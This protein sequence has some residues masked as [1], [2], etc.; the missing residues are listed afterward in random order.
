MAL[1]ST[2]LYK[3]ETASYFDAQM[4]FSSNKLLRESEGFR[5]R[6]ASLRK[7]RA[8]LSPTF[9]QK[10]EPSGYQSSENDAPESTTTDD[11]NVHVS[12]KQKLVRLINEARTSQQLKTEPSSTSSHVEHSRKFMKETKDLWSSSSERGEVDST[13]N[14]NGN[15]DV[16]KAIHDAKKWRAIPD[17][18][19]NEANPIPPCLIY[20]APHLLRLFVEMPQMLADSEVTDARVKI[21]LKHVSLFLEKYVV[22]ENQLFNVNIYK[23]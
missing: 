12:K 15:K 2:L 23:K 7:R 22:N 9:W 3:N 1:S 20:G 10:R 16:Q 11:S 18:S 13:S 17:E 19:L 21:I 14:C 4:N 8:S 5:C 6:S